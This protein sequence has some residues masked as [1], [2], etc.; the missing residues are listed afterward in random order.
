MTAERQE[1][2]FSRKFL[3][4]LIVAGILVLVLVA[5]MIMGKFTESLFQTWMMGLL[6]NF[7]IYGASN[8]VQ[9]FTPGVANQ[10]QG[11]RSA[12]QGIPK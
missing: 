2:L 11:D 10:S 1:A 12:T 7:G 5:V 8:V 3:S 9:K 4:S 6:A